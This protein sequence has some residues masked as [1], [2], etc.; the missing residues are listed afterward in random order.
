MLSRN[1]LLKGLNPTS[2]FK[3]TRLMASVARN[4]QA[5][6][7]ATPAAIKDRATFTIRVSP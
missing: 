4:L 5:T 1:I 6:G 2:A 7:K 3:Q